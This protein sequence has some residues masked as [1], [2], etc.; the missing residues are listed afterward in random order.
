MW[1]LKSSSESES[2]NSSRVKEL[3]EGNETGVPAIVIGRSPF[4]MS[5]VNEWR[6]GV[7]K[8]EALVSKDCHKYQ[9]KVCNEIL[10]RNS[11]V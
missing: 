11:L 5:A 4:A 2:S 10:E 7:G 6:A 3:K 1:A 9:T 8:A